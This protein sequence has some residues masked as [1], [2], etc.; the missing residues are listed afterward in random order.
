MSQ[1]GQRASFKCAAL[2]HD[3]LGNMGLKTG[4]KIGDLVES[5]SGFQGIGKIVSLDEINSKA[6]VAFFVSPIKHSWRRIDVDL[7]Q[8]QSAEIYDEASVYL[9]DKLTGIWRRARY[10]SKRP[11]GGHLVLFKRDEPDIVPIADIHVLNLKEDE[12]LNPSEFLEA[13]YTE[14]PFF[15]EWR[16]P[17]AQSY[18][19]QRAACRSI[20]SILSSSVEIEPHQIA[21]VRRVLQDNTQ[22]Y[23]LADEVG[24]GKTIEAC[25]IIR[26]H[27]LQDEEEAHVLIGVPSGLV[28]QWRSELVSRFYLGD[29]LDTRIF[30]CPHEKVVGAL[31]IE[32]PTMFVVDEAH[33]VCPWAWSEDPREKGDFKVLA[34][35]AQKA[36]A[37]LLLSGT[38]L[39]G[40]ERNFLAMLH[41]LSP[42]SYELT[43]KGQAR[44][45]QRLDERERL[46][47]LYQ[48]LVPENDNDTL[49]DLLDEIGGLFPGDSELQLRLSHARPLVDWQAS[50]E[51]AERLQAIKD[52]RTYI[53]EHYR[54]HQRMLRNRRADPRIASL[55]P[56]LAGVT[57]L[58]W[59]V[60]AQDLSVGQTLDAV[61]DEVVCGGA[62]CT[63]LSAVNYIDWIRAYF[64]SPSLVGS[65]ARQAMDTRN[66]SSNDWELEWLEGLVNYSAQEQV[67]KDSVLMSFLNERLADQP[68]AKFIIFCGEPEIADHVYAFLF[69]QLEDIVERHSPS[70]GLLFR[71]VATT[72]VLVCDAAGEDGLNLHGGEK[73]IVHY[74]I[75]LSFSRIE[76]RNG[77]V[78]RYS[79]AIH[80]RPVESVVLVPDRPGL[81]DEWIS[82]L[83]ESVGIF[84][85]SVASL[86][87]VLQD[88]MD[89]AWERVPE[90]GAEAIRS[91]SQIL[92]GPDGLLERESRKVV[93]Q[94]ELNSMNEEVEKCSSFAE[95][96]E[97]ADQKAEDQAQ[98][99]S[100]WITK[101]LHFKYV[102]GEVPGSF[103]FG[104][105]ADSG[106]GRRTLVDVVSFLQRC[107]TGI[108]KEQSSWQEP[109]TALM[110]PDRQLVSHGGQI[111]P[112]RFG[113]PFVDTIF[114][115]SRTD[116]R[117]IS[118]VRLR[119]V[120]GIGNR[121]PKAYF[122]L[123]WV[124]TGCPLDA[125][126]R[127]QRISDEA[128]SPEFVIHWLEE[129]GDPLSDDFVEALLE[130]PYTKRPAKLG[131][132]ISYQ[133]LNVSHNYWTQLEE[134]FPEAEWSGLVRQAVAR[135]RATIT[136]PSNS[137]DGWTEEHSLQ[138][139]A[140]SVVIL[141][142]S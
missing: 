122:K 10:G 81:F 11:D 88:Q 117:G 90:L 108:D 100:G 118:S 46:G 54:L 51:G 95:S 67:A 20:S 29:L 25:L 96:L 7:D 135:S 138:L 5:R 101:A 60:G 68:N 56:G 12:G 94:E 30:V 21:V 28:D 31:T 61:R 98:K 65:M 33:Q 124:L 70:G 27:V 49:T 24:L 119:A 78:N 55:F 107:L 4:F 45:L 132:G 6:T 110:S 75:P 47:G 43:S 102:P 93:A 23:L 37:C 133:D 105:V 136:R 72:R 1:F 125:D 53:G 77:R 123:A 139:E 16:I 63:T 82:V 76:Q 48:A 40:N 80:A 130:A 44:F 34:E 106:S 114:D 32:Q 120:N 129:A 141:I 131:Q 121:G 2:Q 128:R 103:R 137:E 89:D 71:D 17:F 36:T 50:D 85:R 58:V 52:L 87:Y 22:R 19:E 41:L 113:Q 127:S 83:S 115:L 13:R 3:N 62:E 9:Q 74:A 111:Y 116:T 140:I 18:V 109:V 73:I 64:C 104:Y 142:G 91:L 35:G 97:A 66:E 112:L 26:E 59:E 126:R 134:Y 42:K 39:T 38:P 15:S 14:T 79:A 92:D 69:A 99:M 86:Q 84:N 57:K 8:L